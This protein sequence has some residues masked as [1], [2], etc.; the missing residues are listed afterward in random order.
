MIGQTIS[1]YKILEKLG[2]GGMGVVYKAQDLKLD[3]LVALKFLPSRL[4]SDEKDKQRFVNEAKAASAL[5]HRNICTIYEVDEAPDSQLF[6]V[7]AFY[8]GQTLQQ[9][10]SGEDDVMSPLRLDDAM[11][12]IMQTAEGLQAAHKKGI[13]HRDIKSSNIMV[14]A[15]GQVKM[16]DFGLAKTADAT[17]LTKTGATVGTVPYMSP[18]QARGEKVDHRT[19]IWSLGV[20]LYQMIAGRLPFQSDYHDAIVY[21]IL[22]EEPKPLTSLRSDV[23]MELERIVNKCLQKNFSDRYQ[24]TSELLADLYRFKGV[25]PPIEVTWKLIR[26][27]Y[28][29]LAI[30]AII[31]GGVIILVAAYFLFIADLFRYPTAEA[32][33]NSIA[34]MYFENILDPEDKDH[35]GDMLANLLITSLSQAKGL[36]VMSR[37]RLYHIQKYITRS[38]SKIITPS[39]ATQIAQQAGVRVML[40]GSIVQEEPKLVVTSRLVEVKSGKILSS[41]KLSEFPADRIFSLVDSLAL[42]VRDDMNMS[43]TSAVEAK[44]LTEV[45]TTNSQEAYRAYVEGI[46]L[47][48]KYHLEEARVP[49]KKAIELDSN[50]AMAYFA[51]SESHRT[52]GDRSVQRS[53]LQKA[54][55]LRHKVTEKERM[56]IEGTYACVIENDWQSGAEIL[57]RLLQKY[58]REQGAYYELFQT[59]RSLNE[60]EKA[61]KTVSRALKNDSLDKTLSLYLAYLYAGLGRR[62]E[63]LKVADKYLKLA[64]GEYN[65]YDAKGDVYLIFG[66]ADSALYWNKQLI[67]FGPKYTVKLGSDAV[68]RQDY[69]D[70]EK[71]FKQAEVPFLLFLIPLHQGHFKEARDQLLRID[72]SLRGTMRRLT[73][74]DYEIGDYPSML[75]HAQELSAQLSKDPLNLVHGRDLLAWAHLKNGNKEKAYK[76]LDE[77]KIASNDKS[78]TWEEQ[79]QYD[80]AAA[81]LAYEEQRYDDAL[82]KFKKA[83]HRA[84]PNHYG[85]FFYGVTLLKTGHTTEAID[86]LQRSSCQYPTGW[87]PQGLLG[88]LPT[89]EYWIFASVKAHYWLGVAYEQKGEKAKAIA[90]F[91]KFWNIWKDVDTKIPELVDAKARLAKLKTKTGK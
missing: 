53:T 11:N 28:R 13:V 35:T 66:E 16:M 90:E 12:Y 86:E 1:H 17:M 14:T 77:I 7:M 78:S 89:F 32:P 87:S 84:F 34:V 76:L 24:D 5:D 20:V 72:P 10:I 57:E 56:R 74:L 29:K 67:P 15:E 85:Q 91:E 40:L 36:E 51:L 25:A 21:L 71:Y 73:L 65:P 18:E 63:A 52:F 64:P 4:A 49:L 39:L 55:E 22:N 2:E 48:R 62:E 46:E 88:F 6:I 43:A 33:E 70:A 3:R 61:E 79:C 80:Y 54:W 60:Y 31:V 26:K 75:K 44:P 59:Y 47:A 50:F 83:F 19:D 37:E 27:K 69:S 68:L 82:E 41:Q 42:L 30:P 9:K 81:L 8:E 45:V 38:D 23:P 58:P